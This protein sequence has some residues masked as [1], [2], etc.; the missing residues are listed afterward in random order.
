LSAAARARL[1]HGEAV[2]RAQPLGDLIARR[3]AGHAPCAVQVGLVAARPREHRLGAGTHARRCRAEHEGIVDCRT[4]GLGR[5]GERL[6][7]PPA[8]AAAT[9]GATLGEAVDVGE[10]RARQPIGLAGRRKYF[11]AHVAVAPYRASGEV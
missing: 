11:G 10:D 4:A 5:D 9:P 1:V 8:N 2:E 3:S 7:A 6:G